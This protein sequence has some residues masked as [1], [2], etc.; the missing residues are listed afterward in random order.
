[1]INAQKRAIES[2]DPAAEAELRAVYTDNGNST[3]TWRVEVVIDGK[4][5][6]VESLVEVFLKPILFDD[7]VIAVARKSH[8]FIPPTVR[9]RKL[10]DTRKNTV[11]R[12]D[13]EQPE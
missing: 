4:V 9:A 3:P 2:S 11:K 7:D 6:D 8:A 5:T 12:D 10:L 1:V 13:I